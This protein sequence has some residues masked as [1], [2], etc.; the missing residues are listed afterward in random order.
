MLS[1]LKNVN[2]DVQKVVRKRRT[3]YY[4]ADFFVPDMQSATASAS[5][6][7]RALRQE[8]PQSIDIID[9]KDTVAAWRPGQPII[10]A[11]VTFAVRAD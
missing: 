6:W 8:F 10:C 2:I 5:I 9:T 3:G 11:T 1:L 7:A 4:M